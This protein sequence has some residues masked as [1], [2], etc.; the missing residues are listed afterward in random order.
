MGL[1][2][3]RKEYD[4]FDKLKE[5]LFGK[6]HRVFIRVAWDEFGDV[7]KKTLEDPMGYHQVWFYSQSPWE[8]SGSFKAMKECDQVFIFKR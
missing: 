8:T 7:D 1:A 3:G 4:M 5:I 6:N 2:W